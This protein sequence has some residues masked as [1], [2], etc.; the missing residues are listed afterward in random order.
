[1]YALPTRRATP[2]S[3]VFPLPEPMLRQLQ[4]PLLRRGS[5]SR[6]RARWIVA[7]FLGSAAALL[8]PPLAAQPA[9]FRVSAPEENFRAEPNGPRLAVLQR[10]AR[11]T[12]GEER[13]QWRAVTLEAWVPARSVGAS[14]SGGFDLTVASTGA[15]LHSAPG[16]TV[17]GRAVGGLMLNEVAREGGWVRVR[18]AGWIWAPSL[19]A[20]R[21]SEATAEPRG[22][23]SAVAPQSGRQSGGEPASPAAAPLRVLLSSPARGDTVASLGRGARVEV[24]GREG[25]WARVRVEGWVPLDESG[26]LQQPGIERNVSLH[27]LRSDPD[28]YRG[29]TLQ[30]QVQFMAV[31]RA[32]SLRTDFTRGEPYMLARDPGGEAGLVYIALPPEHLAAARQLTPLQRVEIVARVR[33]GRSPLMG[34]PVLE[35][36]ELRR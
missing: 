1:M 17:L 26:A 3:A 21:G 19:A 36:V 15:P 12:A 29:V 4:A 13:G 10:D 6:S 2:I 14:R 23:A 22:N 34:H 31:Q 32:D 8:A 28:R 9:V 7:T 35:L 18:R 11:L 27:A 5:A 30:W 20:A 25:G 16:G 33:H 24:V